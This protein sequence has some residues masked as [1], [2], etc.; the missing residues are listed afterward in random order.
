M[1]K[2]AIQGMWALSNLCRGQPLPKY[3]MIK[4]AVHIICRYALLN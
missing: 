1:K 3:N 2:L 4:K